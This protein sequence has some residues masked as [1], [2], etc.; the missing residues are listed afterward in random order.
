MVDDAPVMAAGTAITVIVAVA[1]TPYTTYVMVAV[2]AATPVTIPVDEP[3]VATPVLLLLQ[4]PPGE[5]LLSVVVLPAHTVD[6]PVTGAG[7]PDTVTVAVAV[8]PVE[9]V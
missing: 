4:T 2:P 1:V 3:T 9:S 7:E 8:Q 5:R 6:A